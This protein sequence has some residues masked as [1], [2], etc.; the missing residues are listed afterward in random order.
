MIER[1]STS[2]AFPFQT[3]AVSAQL[4][5][6]RSPYFSSMSTKAV[7][8]KL[9]DTPLSENSSSPNLQ[10][11]FQ[12]ATGSI[13]PTAEQNLIL[14]AEAQNNTETKDEVTLSVKTIQ[15]QPLAPDISALADTVFAQVPS[16]IESPLQA[17][18]LTK[19]KQLLTSTQFVEAGIQL[20]VRTRLEPVIAWLGK[21]VFNKEPFSRWLRVTHENNIEIGLQNGDVKTLNWVRQWT[22]KQGQPVDMLSLAK[23]NEGQWQHVI[24]EKAQKTETVPA[25]EARQSLVSRLQSQIAAIE[26]NGWQLRQRAINGVSLQEPSTSTSTTTQVRPPVFTGNTSNSGMTV[27]T[28]ASTPPEENP[29]SF[30]NVLANQGFQYDKA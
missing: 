23:N 4:L 21:H 11:E 19:D 5:S 25:T 29:F 15:M 8:N 26:P 24:Q 20:R 17:A 28:I 7:V 22:T 13:H 2:G 27:T 9:F 12:P 1:V 6:Q 16:S 30:A 10:L 18:Y 3:A 14:F